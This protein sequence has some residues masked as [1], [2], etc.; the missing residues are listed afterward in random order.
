MNYILVVVAFLCTLAAWAVSLGWLHK[1]SWQEWI[2]AALA[3]Y[4]LSLLLPW[5]EARRPA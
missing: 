3:A 5:Y 1:G 4:F 2:A